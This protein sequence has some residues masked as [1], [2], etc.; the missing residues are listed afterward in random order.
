[1][2]KSNGGVGSHLLARIKAMYSSAFL[3]EWIGTIATGSRDGVEVHTAGL[4]CETRS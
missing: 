2:T 3:H 1:M 4:T